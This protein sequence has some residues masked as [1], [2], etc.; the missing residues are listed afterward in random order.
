MHDT[1]L[2]TFTYTRLLTYVTI[3]S[4]CA[5]HV[6]FTMRG[7]QY[8]SL[9]CLLL[10]DN[11]LDVAARVC[12]PATWKPGSGMLCGQGFWDA[13][14]YVDRVSTLSTATIWLPGRKF[15][16]P[17]C[18]RRDVTAQVGNQASKSPHV[19]Q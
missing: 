19:V 11:R 12:N 9:V 17:G 3:E 15:R 18:L 8:L 14:V 16:R 6:W 2:L 7:C 5:V 1:I 4:T 10:L 13:A